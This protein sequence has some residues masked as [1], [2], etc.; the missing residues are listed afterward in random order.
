MPS[1]APEVIQSMT[2]ALKAAIAALPE[3]VQSGHVHLLAESILRSASGGE[4]DTV[5]LQR[6]AMMELQLAPRRAHQ[7]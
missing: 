1:F 7:R 3:P 5:A 4:R 2:V 6:I